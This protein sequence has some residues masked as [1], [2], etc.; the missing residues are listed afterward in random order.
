MT[1]LLPNRR[2]H[3]F[4]DNSRFNMK[5]L[6]LSPNPNNKA[7]MT[8]AEKALLD[9]LSKMIVRDIINTVKKESNAS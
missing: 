5:V 4:G 9:C 6:T 7:A 1:K 3:F 2:L 8:P